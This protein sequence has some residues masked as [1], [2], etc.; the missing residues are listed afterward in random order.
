LW[1]TVKLWLLTRCFFLPTVCCKLIHADILIRYLCSD[2]AILIKIWLTIKLTSALTVIWAQ[3][4]NV[5]AFQL[6][7]VYHEGTLVHYVITHTCLL[8]WLTC[9]LAIFQLVHIDYLLPKRFYSYNSCY[10]IVARIIRQT[11]HSLIG[12]L[13]FQQSRLLIVPKVN[14]IF[15][16]CVVFL[17]VQFWLYLPFLNTFFIF[18]FDQ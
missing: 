16:R 10:S 6:Q 3:W 14:F 18:L 13:N 4:V 5:R 7:V 12:V 1:Q 2:Y 9:E 17:V 15:E 8:L 11:I